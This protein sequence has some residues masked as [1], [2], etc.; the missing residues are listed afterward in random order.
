M[1]VHAF[2]TLVNMSV[3]K[4]IRY[5]TFY[6]KEKYLLF[7]KMFSNMN[8]SYMQKMHVTGMGSFKQ[9]FI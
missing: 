9:T 8:I 7:L 6:S 3:G 2:P 4:I 1:A 5:V